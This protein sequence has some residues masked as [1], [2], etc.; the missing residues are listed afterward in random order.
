MVEEAIIKVRK[1]KERSKKPTIK[2]KLAFNAILKSIKENKQTGKPVIS[3]GRAM[4]LGGYSPSS[5]INPELNLTS[6]EG[7]QRLLT[8]IDDT[9]LLD[10]VMGIVR[11][12]ANRE[13]LSAVDMMFKLKD[14]Y[15]QKD[16]KMV[17]LFTKIETLGIEE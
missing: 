11:T 13:K 2:Q 16:T 9:E 1:V 5:A 6:K 4:I 15:P 3:M 8:R 14:R 17:S 10:T 12:G 7:F